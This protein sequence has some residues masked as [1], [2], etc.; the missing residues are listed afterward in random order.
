MINSEA[1]SEISPYELSPDMGL[2]V[3]KDRMYKG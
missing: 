2:F 3:N 1:R